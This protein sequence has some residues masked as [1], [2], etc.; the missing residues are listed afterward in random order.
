MAEKHKSKYKKPENTKYKSRKDL[1]DYTTDDKAGALNPYSTKQKQSNVLRK[2]DKNVQDDG[3]Y[4]VKYNADDRL[5]KD[6]ED[7]EYD[8]K[9]AAKVFKK[10]QD[11]EEKDVSDVIKDKVENLTRE[12]RER[13]VRE[14]VRRKIVKILVEQPKPAE[15]KPADKPAE[16][17]P[18]PDAAAPPAPS[19]PATP[20]P[21]AA[22]ETPAPDA[23]AAP[24]ATPPPAADASATPPP[25]EEKPTADAEAEKQVSPETKEALDVDRFVQY[26][27]KQEGNIAKLKSIIKVV[28]LSLDKAEVEDQANVW[29]MLKIT[30]NKKLAKLGTQSNNK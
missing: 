29:K 11:K 25:A 16:E 23:G 22:A 17:T 9:H 26:L 12:Q 4:D 10:R 18:A 20:A 8:A 3:K 30:S 6:L 27:K 2:T 13:L 14:Y 24:A 15:E 19:A 1:K 28:N 5:Y 21:D 7:G